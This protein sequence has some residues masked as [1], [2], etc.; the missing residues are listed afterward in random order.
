MKG[1]IN[2]IIDVIMFVLMALLAGI[3]L[4]IK[5]IL[6]SGEN[7]WIK[8]GRN[9][10]LNFWG[11]DRH[12]WGTI[13][14]WVAVALVVLL[15]LHIILHWN[16]II[17]LYKKLIGNKTGRVICGS[18]L[19]VITLLFVV[20]PFFIKVDMAEI[21]PG[22][23]RFG[24]IDKH[25]K[26]RFI[27]NDSHHAISDNNVKMSEQTNIQSTIKEKQENVK[28]EHNAEH[29]E[30]DPAIEVKG[31]NTLNEVS[32][33]YN[34][35]ISVITEKLNIPESTSG[36]SKLGHL[37]KQYGFTMSDIELIIHNYKNQ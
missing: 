20:F 4:L 14:L 21:A 7:R 35:P 13:H 31:Y 34:I 30:I 37:R 28:E 1:K 3:G 15:I 29:Q 8:Y 23:E 12:E 26:Q 32:Q 24:S 22:R 36:S 17:C 33:L 16:M 5:Y 9:V 2:F 6:L 10:D 27:E 19:S 11:L 25:E 18:A